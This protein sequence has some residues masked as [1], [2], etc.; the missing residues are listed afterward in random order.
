MQLI[1]F[2]S[3]F[4]NSQDSHTSKKIFY[5][6]DTKRM[7]AGFKF[8]G[9]TGSE[10]FACATLPTT[11]LDFQGKVKIFCHPTL[12]KF[13]FKMSVTPLLEKG[14]SQNYGASINYNGLLTLSG[15][16]SLK[17]LLHMT[18]SFIKENH[19]NNYI[20]AIHGVQNYNKT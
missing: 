7:S 15:L 2:P 6:R 18:T 19:F 16:L 13:R 10:D 8:W 14:Q 11:P 3:K 20:Q 4:S 1:T 9:V 12:L 17:F 5:V